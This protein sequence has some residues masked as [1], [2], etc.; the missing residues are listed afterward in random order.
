MRE[1]GITLRTWVE[2]GKEESKMSKE[3]KEV[4]LDP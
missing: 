4:C 2:R 3:K 1:R